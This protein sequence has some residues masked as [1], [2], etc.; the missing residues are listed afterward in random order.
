[1]S[2]DNSAVIFV[3]FLYVQFP[4]HKIHKGRLGIMFI[5]YLADY[6]D[7]RDWQYALWLEIRVMDD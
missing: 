2:A 7:N 3:L 6:F 1:M 4:H 5:P